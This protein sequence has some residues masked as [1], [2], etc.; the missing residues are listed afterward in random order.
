MRKFIVNRFY[1]V[2]LILCSTICFVVQRPDIIIQ[3][4]Y[5]IYSAN[6]AQSIF[7]SSSQDHQPFESEDE[8]EYSEN[9]NEDDTNHNRLLYFLTSTFNKP[10]FLISDG[11]FIYQFSSTANTKVSETPTF[12]K[13]RQ[14]II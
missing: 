14:L 10:S 3:N 13:Y 8:E 7:T 11:L 4:H 6:D 2:G 1:L 5:H 12:I 9:E